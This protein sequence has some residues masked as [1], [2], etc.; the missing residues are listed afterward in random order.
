MIT[1]KTAFLI[2]YL[3]SIPIVLYFCLKDTKRYIDDRALITLGNLFAYILLTFMPC[4]NTIG[5]IIL[6]I[7]SFYFNKR[8]SLEDWYDNT[9]KKI[10]SFFERILLMKGEKK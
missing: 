5:A 2:I 3:I 1:V 7:T 9:N 8:D 4:L 10:T 6:T